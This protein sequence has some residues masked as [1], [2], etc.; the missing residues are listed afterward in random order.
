MSLLCSILQGVY[1]G[2]WFILFWVSGL[3]AS[4]LGPCEDLV[5]GSRITDESVPTVLPVIAFNDV[6]AVVLK[7]AGWNGNDHGFVV[8]NELAG[9]VRREILPCLVEGRKY[10]IGCI[11]S[12]AVEGH[13]IHDH[14][15]LRSGLGWRVGRHG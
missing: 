8:T 4:I 5:F 10:P 9:S 6:I 1:W 7:V 3:H 15:D 11:I 13:G 14:E 12:L 2:L